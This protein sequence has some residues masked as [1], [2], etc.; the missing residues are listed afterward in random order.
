MLVVPSTGLG[1]GLIPVLRSVYF[2][3]VSVRE[4]GEEMNIVCRSRMPE[5][6]TAAIFV[7]QET[8]IAVPSV[9]S[10]IEL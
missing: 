6:T 10:I 7:S 1:R 4:L 8:V 5:H 3:P 9:S 2:P